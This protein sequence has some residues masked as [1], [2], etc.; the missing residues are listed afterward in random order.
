MKHELELLLKTKYPL[1]FR[2][3]HNEK[4][5]MNSTCMVW[6]LECG[7]G[8]FN[9]LDELG[10]KLEPLIANLVKD[11]PELGEAYTAIQVKEKF[12]GLRFYMNGTTD[13]IEELISEA[14]DLSYKTCE[15]CGSPGKANATGW[16]STLCDKCRSNVR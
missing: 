3:L 13:E 1:L 10:S 2:D 7:D 14:E 8:W 6:G 5:S 16:I 15:K 4:A 9:I 11:K 12:G